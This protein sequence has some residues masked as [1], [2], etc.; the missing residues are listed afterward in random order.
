MYAPSLRDRDAHAAIEAL[1]EAT[2]Q[3][4]LETWASD[5]KHTALIISLQNLRDNGYIA[6]QDGISGRMRRV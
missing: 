5:C 2:T 1:G 4:I 6:H 3:M